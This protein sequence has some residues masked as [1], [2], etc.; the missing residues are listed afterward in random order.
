ME[1]LF[2]NVQLVCT[3]AACPRS[4]SVTS[5]RRCLQVDEWPAMSLWTDE[6]LRKAFEGHKLNAGG[7]MLTWDN[8]LAYSS[9]SRWVCPW[10]H[11][12][13]VEKIVL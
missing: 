3:L 6:Y 12:L 11:R 10:N 13:C 1:G 5:V 2:T 4:L 8:W 9:G 7:C